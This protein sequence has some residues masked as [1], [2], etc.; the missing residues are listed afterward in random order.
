MKIK[1]LEIERIGHDTFKIKGKNVVVYTDPYLIKKGEP[2]GLILISHEH[3]DHCD[4]AAV[5]ALS[6]EKTDIVASGLAVKLLGKGKALAPGQHI[7]AKGVEIKG[8]PAYNVKRFRSPGV[9]FH[10]PESKML[11]FV[12]TVDGIKIYFAGDT[13]FI[14]PMNEL[15]KEKID[16]ALLPISDVYVMNE[17]EALEAVKAIKPKIVIPMHYGSLPQVK[18]NPEK[19]KQLV[20]SN[21]EVVIVD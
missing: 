11:S 8:F 16:I 18:G 5:E 15:A 7:T 21:A 1:G 4:T 20:G 12:F 13:D 3:K 2:A 6:N 19:F 9:P 17:E 14:P 10:P